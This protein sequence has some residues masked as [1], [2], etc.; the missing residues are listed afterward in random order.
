[1]LDLYTDE[2]FSDWRRPTTSTVPSA[3]DHPNSISCV[4]TRYDL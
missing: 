2:L 3:L 4:Q 1:M